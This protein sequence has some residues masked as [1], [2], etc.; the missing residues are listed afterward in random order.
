MRRATVTLHVG[1]GTFRP[2]ACTDVRD[3]HLHAERFEISA[4]TVD[5]VERCRRRGGRVVAVGTTNVRALESATDEDGRLRAGP[6]S[7]RLFIHP[8]YRFRQL[9]AL[10]TNFHAPRSS[11][12]M[13]IAA[14]AGRERVMGA[15]RHAIHERYRLLS[16]GDAMFIF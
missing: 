6:G 2:V 11:L 12:L 10:L 14:F 1:P 15:Y 8:P 7:T 16:Y 9:D 3:H 4:A 5:A 13:M